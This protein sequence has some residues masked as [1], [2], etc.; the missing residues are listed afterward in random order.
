MKT[1][2]ALWKKEKENGKPFLSGKIDLGVL[3]EIDIAVFPNEK[4][5][6]GQP[7]YRICLF[8]K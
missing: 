1:V 4:Q 6:E 5:K 3:G 2:G 8:D 7:Q